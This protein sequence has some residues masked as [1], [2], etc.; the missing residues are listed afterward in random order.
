M[1]DYYA[2]PNHILPTGRRARYAS[3]LTA[4]DFRKVTSV[5]EYSPEGVAKA[6]PDVIRL[7]E[8]EGLA[9]HA[10]AVQARQ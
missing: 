3:P 4:E 7:A 6:A 9:A 2:G 10:R 8:A 1:G 5:I